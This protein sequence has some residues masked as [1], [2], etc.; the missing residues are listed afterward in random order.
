[1]IVLIVWVNSTNTGAF[2][3][4]IKS[5]VLFV[6]YLKNPN[7]F[8]FYLSAGNRGI[9]AMNYLLEELKQCNVNKC[10]LYR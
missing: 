2:D 6:F 7:L 5:S 1:M 3:I 10:V 9:S 8:R 4:T